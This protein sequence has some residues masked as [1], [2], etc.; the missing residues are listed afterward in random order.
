LSLIEALVMVNYLAQLLRNTKVQQHV[1]D[2]AMERSSQ[3]GKESSTWSRELCKRAT[4]VGAPPARDIFS[5]AASTDDKSRVGVNATACPCAAR[6]SSFMA[7][8]HLRE[9]G[10]SC[11]S[12]TINPVKRLIDDCAVE[13]R[14]ERPKTLQ[15]RPGRA[16]YRPLISGIQDVGVKEASEKQCDFVQRSVPYVDHGL[17]AFQGLTRGISKGYKA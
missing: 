7:A 13:E 11:Q 10:N 6:R 8:S 5:S 17:K 1:A 15:A 9:C 12:T 4:D 14:K 2:N 16:D 3:N